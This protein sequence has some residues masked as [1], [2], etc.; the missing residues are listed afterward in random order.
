MEVQTKINFSGDEYPLLCT[1]PVLEA[2]C[3]E[4]GDPIAFSEK[5][6]PSKTVD[7]K[8]IVDV[9]KMPDVHA[10]RF[11]LPLMVH[12]GIKLHNK[13]HHI[14]IKDIDDDEL[15]LKNDQ[16]LIDVAMTIHTELWRS[17]NAP[18]QQPHTE[19]SR[20]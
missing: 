5:I 15:F 13:N 9:T 20:S 16:S 1:I 4:F 8:K 18:K 6:I 12:A 11:A 14:E 19:T 17:I 2:I 3:K 10:I 7:D